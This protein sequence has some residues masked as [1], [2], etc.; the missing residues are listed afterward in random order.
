MMVKQVL[1]FVSQR[2]PIRVTATMRFSVNIALTPTLQKSVSVNC[3]EQSSGNSYANM[4][5]LLL[6]QHRILR[7]YVLT[8]EIGAVWLWL[9]CDKV[10]CS[11]TLRCSLALGM[12]YARFSPSILLSRTQVALTRQ[13][14][15]HGQFRRLRI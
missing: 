5:I 9:R 12:W 4:E 6:L 11:A 1:Y 3:V 10:A 2:F 7:D 14:H 8:L 13:L 15:L